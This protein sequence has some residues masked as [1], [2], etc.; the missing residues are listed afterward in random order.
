MTYRL[1]RTVK[2][3][4]PQTLQSKDQVLPL[5]YV[6]G[7]PL[8][9]LYYSSHFTLGGLTAIYCSCSEVMSNDFERLAF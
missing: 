5:L 2:L 4:R 8:I 6:Q 1:W 9:L 3:S 7:Q